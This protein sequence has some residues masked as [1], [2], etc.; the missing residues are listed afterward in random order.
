LDTIEPPYL[1]DMAVWCGTGFGTQVER[2]ETQTETERRRGMDYAHLLSTVNQPLLNRG[3]A[4][5]FF[6]TL[7]DS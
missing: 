1:V 3:D 7:F 4:F 5:L 2:K 6:D